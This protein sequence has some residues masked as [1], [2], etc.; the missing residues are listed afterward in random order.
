MLC[1]ISRR[2][3]LAAG[4]LKGR[5]QLSLVSTGLRCLKT[6][7]G[8]RTVL[9]LLHPN[10]NNEEEAGAEQRR[11]SSNT[12]CPLDSAGQKQHTS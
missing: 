7:E 6:L 8:Q 4:V 10:L 5:R 12:L 9:L 3:K 2:W 1:A 11:A